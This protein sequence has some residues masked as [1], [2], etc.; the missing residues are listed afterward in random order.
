MCIL[1]LLYVVKDH[2]A[3]WEGFEDV[4]K[5]ILRHAVVDWEVKRGDKFVLPVLTL[6]EGLIEAD[7]GAQ[8]KQ[9][10]PQI[11]QLYKSCRLYLILII[12]K[13]ILRPDQSRPKLL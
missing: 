11:R 12:N 8:G 4:K 5:L 6:V 9:E 7:R 13:D 3:E 1:D 10:G 2:H